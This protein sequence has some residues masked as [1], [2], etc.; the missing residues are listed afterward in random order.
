MSLDLASSANSNGVLLCEDM[1]S[2]VQSA[3]H[4]TAHSRSVGSALS[5][6]GSESDALLCRTAAWLVFLLDSLDRFESRA[7]SVS[8]RRSNCLRGLAFFAH[9]SAVATAPKLKTKN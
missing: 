6:G 9:S 7:I 8:E 4:V 1:T 5:I 3:F 2:G